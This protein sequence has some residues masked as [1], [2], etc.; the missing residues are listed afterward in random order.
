MNVAEI[1]QSGSINV[2]AATLYGEAR[3]EPIEGLIACGCVVRN[4]VLAKQWDDNYVDVCL[5]PKQFSCWNDGDPNRAMCIK[6]LM[7]G[8][9]NDSAYVQC[10]WVAHGIIY[11]MTIDNTNG[12]NH[13]FN[14]TIVW[15]DWAANFHPV[16]KHGSH[17]FFR[18]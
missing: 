4:R 1:K 12:A 3:G 8:R 9:R 7:R 10:R 16:A 6:A 14:P 2:L 11:N 5:Q 15:P 17:L 18:L 13:Y